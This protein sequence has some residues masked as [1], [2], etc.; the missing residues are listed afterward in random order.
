L[1]HERIGLILGPYTKVRRAKRRLEGYQAA[2]SDNGLRFDPRLVIEKHPTLQEGKEAMQKLLS[3]RHPPTAVFAASDM[4]AVG[5]LA[6]AREKGVRVP[7]D[8]SIAGFD[9]IDFAAYCNPPLTTVRVPAAQMGEM[10]VEMLLEMIEGDSMHVRQIT[11]DTEL[12]I[13][14]SCNAV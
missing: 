1:K 4:L 6:A 7:E 11:L 10:A 8:L 12:V 2:L 5:A 13:R 3:M 14:E 9:D